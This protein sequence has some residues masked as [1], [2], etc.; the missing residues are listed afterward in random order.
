MVVRVSTAVRNAAVNA[1]TALVDAGAAAGKLRVY[2]GGQPGGGPNASATGTLLV[3]ITLGDPASGSA[4]SGS[5]DFDVTPVPTGT[6]VATGTAGWA[7]L[8][9]SNNAALVDGTVAGPGGGG[10]FTVD[11]TSVVVGAVVSVTGL[12]LG[13]ASS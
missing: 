1:A 6:A 9:D 3:E 10:D 4:A 5:A 12:S 2:T 8:L 11:T 7:R 13:Q